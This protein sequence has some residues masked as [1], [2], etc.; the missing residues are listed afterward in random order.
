M[1]PAWA[2]LPMARAR[3]V[4][5][6][7][8]NGRVLRCTWASKPSLERGEQSSGEVV[9]VDA[10]REFPV[11]MKGSEFIAD[12]GCPLIEPCRD[13]GPGLGVAL[14]ELAAERA[15]WAAPLCFGALRCGDHHVPPGFDSLR[16]AERVPLVIDDGVGLV[17]DDRP[18]EFVLVGEVVVHLRAAD[19]RRHPDVFQGGAC[20]P[21][22]MDQ[23]GGLLDY[24]CPG[25]CSLGGEPRAV[26]RLVGHAPRLVGIWV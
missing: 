22:L 24:S 21:A 4:S 12:G 1:N 19:F 26:T 3:R 14:G 18:H 16:A 20:Y 2:H 7:V 10:G 8:S 6:A 5:T 17:V 15:E 23:G 11:G 9:R 13:E 25:A